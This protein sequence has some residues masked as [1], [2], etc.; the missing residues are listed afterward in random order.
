MTIFHSIKKFGIYLL[1]TRKKI[2]V[3]PFVLMNSSLYPARSM[4]KF[5]PLTL[6]SIF[7]KI[8]KIY[9]I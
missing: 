4:N 1:S 8:A 2:T 7:E 9:F 5:H 6:H 3:K